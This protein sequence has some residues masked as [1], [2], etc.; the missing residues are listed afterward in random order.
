MYLIGNVLKQTKDLILKSKDDFFVM[1][2][3]TLWTITEIDSEYRYYMEEFNREILEGR[4]GI[5]VDKDFIE[6]IFELNKD[7]VL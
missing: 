2:V 5:V 4:Y 3:N 6:N 7:D 1:P